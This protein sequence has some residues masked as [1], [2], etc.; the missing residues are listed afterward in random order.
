M[1][2]VFTILF[3]SFLFFPG[4]EEEIKISPQV[5]KVVNV[6]ELP[7]QESWNSKISFTDSGKTKSVLITGHI[8]F[9][10]IAQETYLDNEVKVDFYDEKEIKTTTLTSHR[11]RVDDRTKDIYAI[12]NVVVVNDSGMT[13]KSEKLMWRNLDRKITTDEFVTI[14]TP[15]EVIKGY[16]FE[17]DQSLRNYKIHKVTYVT[18]VEALK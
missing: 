17:S 10:A 9:F 5:D 14:T 11:A 7:T 15:Y 6:K 8:Q 18:D 2:F 12:D 3:F 1:K 4:C 13:L 16:G